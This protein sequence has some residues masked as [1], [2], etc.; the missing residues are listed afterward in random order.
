MEI[1]VRCKNGKKKKYINFTVTFESDCLGISQQSKVNPIWPSFLGIST[2]T[3]QCTNIVV[4]N[5]SIVAGHL[6]EILLV[7]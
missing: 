6:G 3:F 4:A 1:D 2:L 5:I 7:Q